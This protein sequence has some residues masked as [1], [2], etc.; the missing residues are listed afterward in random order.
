MKS[1]TANVQQEEE[2]ENTKKATGDID[3][4]LKY[5]SLCTALA[6]HLVAHSMNYMVK[7]LLL[8]YSTSP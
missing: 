6:L 2:E 1:H 4:I 5:N 8:A 7:K 3:H